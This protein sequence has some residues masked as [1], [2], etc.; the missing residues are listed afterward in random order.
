VSVIT[1]MRQTLAA[2]LA[3]AGV[4]VHAAWP[5]RPVIPCLV[6]VPGVS[7][8][9]TANPGAPFGEY[10]LWVDVLLLV[11]RDGPGLVALEALDS[12]LEVVLANTVDWALSAVDAPSLV[13]VGPQQVLGC[14]ISLSKAFRL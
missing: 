3:P 4:P 1:T 6:V 11:R 5:E 10:A 9:V 13:A 2:D 8:Y 7:S 12:L 14:L